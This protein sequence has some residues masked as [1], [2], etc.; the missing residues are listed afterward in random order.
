M[1][2]RARWYLSAKAIRE[3]AA[4]VGRP[5]DDGG[6]LWARVEREL[7]AA[8]DAAHLLPGL[9]QEGHQRWRTG[10]PLRLQLVVSTQQR[11]EG[12]L[13]QLVGVLG[14]PRR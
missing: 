14:R 1:T 2:L 7:A 9:T 4:I 3:Y 6:P 12:T 10:R 5:L 11:D 13:D 8:C